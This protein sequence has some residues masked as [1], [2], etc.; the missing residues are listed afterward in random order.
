VPFA[1]G[2][3]TSGSILPPDLEL[4]VPFP[5]LPYRDAVGVIVAGHRQRP[6]GV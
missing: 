2:S 6:P 1:I 5:D 3:E 4:D